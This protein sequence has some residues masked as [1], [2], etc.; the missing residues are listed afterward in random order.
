ML[1]FCALITY[2]LEYY[3]QFWALTS[4]QTCSEMGDQDFEAIS[5]EDILSY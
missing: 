2:D 1:L 3:F 4:T 5:N